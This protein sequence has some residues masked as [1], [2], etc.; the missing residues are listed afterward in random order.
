MFSKDYD[1]CSDPLALMTD[2]SSIPA[3]S[4]RVS[5]PLEEGT[6]IVNKL[7]FDG[8]VITDENNYSGN[9]V[10]EVGNP[11]SLEKVIVDIN[12]TGE[13]REATADELK[14]GTM[15]IGDLLPNSTYRIYVTFISTEGSSVKLTLTFTTRKESEDT[16]KNS[17]VGLT[18]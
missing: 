5:A 7:T 14:S 17:L 10:W 6:I 11:E 18:W 8:D 13:D 12:G 15:K 9:I 16:T 3:M 1:L 4:V 2:E